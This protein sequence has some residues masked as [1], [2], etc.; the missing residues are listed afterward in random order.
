MKY[1]LTLA[2]VALLSISAFAQEG[3]CRRADRGC[4]PRPAAGQ[5]CA[6]KAKGKCTPEKILKCFDA[7]KDGSLCAAEIATMQKKMAEK[8]A[9]CTEAKKTKCKKDAPKVDA[10]KK[11]PKAKKACTPEQMMK[12]FDKN[13]DGTLCTA[14]L[15]AMQKAIAARMAGK[16]DGKGPKGPKAPRGRG[17]RA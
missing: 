4:R 17:P 13:K 8:R 14:E 3:Q 5:H 2:A 11:G 15:G 7:N 1:S 16:K 12:R 9:K 10:P 6:D